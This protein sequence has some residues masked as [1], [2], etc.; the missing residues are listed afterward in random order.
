MKICLVCDDTRWVC[1]EHPDRPW[2]GSAR[3]CGG[4]GAG[5]PCP[6]CSPADAD[7]LPAGFEV[8]TA[9]DLDN[10]PT[11]EGDGLRDDHEES[12]AR[13]RRH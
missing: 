13:L 4:G 5:M 7:T 6:A 10:Y 1:E 12:P 9:R 2:E 3:A 11:M 8:D